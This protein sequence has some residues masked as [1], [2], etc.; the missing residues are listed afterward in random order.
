MAS[1]VGIVVGDETGGK[2]VGPLYSLSI[3]D[4]ALRWGSTNNDWWECALTHLVLLCSQYGGVCYGRIGRAI[5]QCV[6]LRFPALIRRQ[7]VTG[8][9]V[10]LNYRIRSKHVLPISAVSARGAYL[11]VLGEFMRIFGRP[12]VN[13]TQ[14]TT[15]SIKLLLFIGVR[16]HHKREDIAAQRPQ[17]VQF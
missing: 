6:L 1:Y 11:Q 17:I 2:N 3:D 7:L 13:Q 8:L 9:Q 10:A 15:E 4:V 14:W 5:L 16:K 12:C